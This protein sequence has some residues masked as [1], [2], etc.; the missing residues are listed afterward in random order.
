MPSAPGF[1]FLRILLSEAASPERRCSLRDLDTVVGLRH[2]L[3]RKKRI[4]RK[5][6]DAEAETG[7][8]EF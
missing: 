7:V 3:A 4:S 5:T 6:R 1:C 2:S 8:D